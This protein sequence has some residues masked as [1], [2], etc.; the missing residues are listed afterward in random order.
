MR[1]SLKILPRTVTDLVQMQPVMP[2]R[3]DLSAL[4]VNYRRIP[5]MSIGRDIYCDTRLIINKLE[6]RFPDGALGAQ[7]EDQKGIERLLEKWTGDALFGRAVQCLPLDLPL[8][9]DPAFLKDRSEFQ[10]QKWEKDA[11]EQMRPEALVHI[12]HAFDLLETTFLAD[13][14]N[15]IFKT[16]KPSLAD[17][18]AIW[19]FHWLM[20]MP[21]AIPCEVVSDKSHPKVLAWIARFRDALK[22]AQTPASAPVMLKGPEAVKH[23]VGA[24]VS[25][26]GGN[27]ASNDPL[28]LK[29]GVNVGVWP[30][31]SGFS[32]HDQGRLVTLT[33]EEVAIAVQS[34]VGGK[35]VHVHMPRWN[36]R[37]TAADSGAKL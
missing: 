27:V 9:S 29:E 33:S 37:I 32:K 16:Q 34:T 3:E 35:E 18:E 23:I 4:G 14:R 24:E 2:P 7:Q 13:G 22:S 15:W 21:G 11:I 25:E 26:K 31:D 1:M 12:R 28:G 19:P 20:D 36:F 30:I 17:I 6:E 10:G 5:V 8:L